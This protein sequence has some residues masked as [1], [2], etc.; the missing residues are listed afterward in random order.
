MQGITRF[1]RQLRNV[2]GGTIIEIGPGP[3]GITRALLMEGA[4]RVIVIE[5][6]K[7]FVPALELIQQQ[8]MIPGYVERKEGVKWN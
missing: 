2:E 4:E 5:K 7:R 6:D 1:A 3:G 8:A